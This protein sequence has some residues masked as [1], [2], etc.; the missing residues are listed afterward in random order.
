M[1]ELEGTGEIPFSAT[2][3]LKETEAQR[4]CNLPKVIQHIF[5]TG[6]N[7]GL[8]ICRYDLLVFLKL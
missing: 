2:I 6:V 4:G 8:L 1:L 5:I 7:Q 3:V